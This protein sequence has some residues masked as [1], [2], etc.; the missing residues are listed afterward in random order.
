[1]PTA[2]APPNMRQFSCRPFLICV[3][4]MRGLGGVGVERDVGVFEPTLVPSEG[5]RW[6]CVEGERERK[7]RERES[8]SLHYALYNGSYNES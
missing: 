4:G 1:M 3:V 6:V 8:S 2:C 5:A 7:E